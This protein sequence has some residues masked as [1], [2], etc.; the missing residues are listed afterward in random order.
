[1]KYP[2]LAMLLCGLTVWAQ[3]TGT[4]NITTG[5]ITYSST[6]KMLSTAKTMTLRTIRFE[7]MEG[8]WIN[9]DFAGKEGNEE[10]CDAIYTG[11]W[12]V[13]EAKELFESHD[14]GMIYVRLCKAS[15]RVPLEE[16]LKP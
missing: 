1:M 6:M 14:R 15:H 9:L 12:T 11:T 5:N 16:E 7:G 4:T 10:K 13:A 8:D 2:L 3:S